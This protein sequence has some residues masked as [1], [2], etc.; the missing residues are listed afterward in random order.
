MLSPILFNIMLSVLELCLLLGV[1]LANYANDMTSLTK[2]K[3]KSTDAE[4]ILKKE[5]T[6]Q[7]N[8][9]QNGIQQSKI[10]YIT[11][12]RRYKFKKFWPKITIESYDFQYKANPKTLGIIFN[13]KLFWK[14]HISLTDQ[15]HS[16]INLLIMVAN[17]SW[18]MGT[19]SLR[20]LY[21]R[22]IINM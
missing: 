16:R 21:I 7:L 2:N 10:E 19:L 17:R 22:P 15:T 6:F 1:N 9:Q 3:D 8:G 5:L 14:S 11:F 4:I 13:E 12:T 20:Q 18:G